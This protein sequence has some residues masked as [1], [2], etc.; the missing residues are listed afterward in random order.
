M[1]EI[2]DGFAPNVVAVRAVGSVSGADYETVLSPALERAT[3]GD[4]KAR[5]LIELGSDFTGYDASGIAADAGLGIGHLTDFER[6]AVVT[7]V[8]WLRDAIGIFGR[9]I[10]GDVRLF[11]VD[12]AEAARAWIRE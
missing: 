10:Q 2:I 9:L 12:E 1:F 5:F 7:D 11:A 6:I 8:H 3:T 4:S